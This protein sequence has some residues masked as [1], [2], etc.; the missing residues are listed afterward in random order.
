MSDV[1]AQ[2]GF[3]SGIKINIGYSSWG[4]CANALSGFRIASLQYVGASGSSSFISAERRSVIYSIN[5][6]PDI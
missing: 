5:M 6:Y 3:I 1:P 2:E 4:I